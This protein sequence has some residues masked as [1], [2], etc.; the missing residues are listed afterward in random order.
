[1][2][3][4]KEEGEREETRVYEEE[5]WVY[6]EEEGER[7]QGVLVHQEEWNRAV[8]I[9]VNEEED[10]EKMRPREISD[11]ELRGGKCILNVGEEGEMRNEKMLIMGKS[12]RGW[13][14]VLFFGKV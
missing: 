5:C 12:W 6:E 2:L 13:K 1:M 8:E 3:G 7:G 10:S 14:N 11:G 4:E 9:I